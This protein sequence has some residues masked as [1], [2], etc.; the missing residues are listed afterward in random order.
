[1]EGNYCRNINGV[2]KSENTF[3]IIIIIVIIRSVYKIVNN[4]AHPLLQRKD[5][6]IIFAAGY[7]NHGKWILCSV[8]SA[9]KLMRILGDSSEKKS[10]INP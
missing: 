9:D 5:A 7:E 10:E 1:M 6:R 4:D 3:L 8:C 2:L